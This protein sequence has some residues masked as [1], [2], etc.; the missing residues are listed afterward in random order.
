[1]GKEA[2]LGATLGDPAGRR[3]WKR[4][5]RGG[6]TSAARGEKKTARLKKETRAD[7]KEQGAAACRKISREGGVGI[8]L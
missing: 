5:E 4:K 7:K 3:S 1:M 8:G 2:E 6:E